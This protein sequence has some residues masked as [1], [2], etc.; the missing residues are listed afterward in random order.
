MLSFQ[1][2]STTMANLH[3]EPTT[4]NGTLIHHVYIKETCHLDTA[5]KFKQVYFSCHEA[6]H[7][8]FTKQD[9]SNIL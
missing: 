7:C 6:I 9:T 8:T 2:T 4:E 3:T 1:E 5:T